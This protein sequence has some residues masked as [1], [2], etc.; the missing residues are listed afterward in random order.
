MGFINRVGETLGYI[1]SFYDSEIDPYTSEA[2][3]RTAVIADVHTDPNTGTVLEVGVGDPYTIYVIVQDSD[4]NL[5]LTRGGT[6]S[7]YEFT[8][9]M[10][11]R[12]TDEQWQEMLDTTPPDTPE[13]MQ[14]EL[15]ITLQGA[16]V[17]MVI[18]RKES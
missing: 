3:D 18:S 4:G 15:P 12:L 10:D 1:A 2:D 6:F 9:P 14:E 7:Y 13:W 8:Q 16:L 11:D 17:S 5:K